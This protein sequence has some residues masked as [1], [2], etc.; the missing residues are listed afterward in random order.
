MLKVIT[1]C[2]LTS[3]TLASVARAED[4]NP[5]YAPSSLPLQ[6]PPFD[7]IE[8]QHFE[9]AILEG[10]R[11]QAQEVEAI[12]NS[13]EAPT[14]DNTIAAME[15]SGQLL[16]RVQHALGIIASAY[17]NPNLEK[18]QESVAPKL[19]AHQDAIT[20]N[21][22]LFKRIQKI[23][24]T[25]TQLKLTNEQTKLVEY[26][27]TT[28]VLAG[29][30]LTGIKKSKVK[31]LNEEEAKLSTQFVQRLMSATKSA[32]MLISDKEELDGLSQGDLDIAA[33]AAEAAGHK[34]QWLIS[35]QNTTQQ[36]VLASLKNRAVRERLF[37]LAWSRSE[38]E[39][40]D[41]ERALILR[42][43]SIRADKAKIM[44]FSNYATWKL[45]DQMAKTP[46]AVQKL[47]LDLG[48]PASAK[49]KA[50][51]ADIQ[52]LIDQQHGDFQLQ[53]WDW[54]F[55]AN[56]VR[57]AKYDVDESEVR[58]YFELNTVLNDGVF[59]AA[60]LLYG[61]TFK[62]RNDLPVFAPDVRVFDVMDKDGS[63][64]GLFYFDAFKRDN[65]NG[66]AWMENLV[67][68]TKLLGQKP[69]IFVATN[70]AK[71]TSGQAAL[72]NF[73]EVITLFHEFGHAL[74]GF[75][76]DQVYPTVSGTSTARDWV[77]FPSQF[78]EHWASDP[79]VF[80]NYAKH[81]STGAAMPQEMVEKIQKARF[82][83]QGYT[84]TE[85]LG[86]SHLD[87]QWHALNEKTVPKDVGAFEAKA[88]AS[89][90][91][92]LAQVPPRYRSTYFLHIWG[93]GYA[94][95]YYAYT[96]TRVLGDDAFSWFAENGGLTRENGQRFRDMILSRG[97]TIEY[98]KMFRDFRGR[99]VS[100]EAFLKYHGFA[101]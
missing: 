70:V 39:G 69:V 18:V 47:L 99:D 95:G 101:K 75:F 76:A 22:K 62:E 90:G 50:E 64:L 96:W 87:L 37:K 17:T 65:K 9:P 83:N 12:A 20:F 25:R 72:I 41:D 34:G 2:L 28:A 92:N 79:K 14:F 1:A 86:A 94:S 23:Y 15:R 27:Y 26:Y 74:H 48:A 51:S 38:Q 43:A 33:Q 52:A 98:A 71:P 66:G 54:E 49:V 84:L 30:K 8:D 80:A 61:L 4:K 67:T 58:P 29:A 40:K 42:L 32:A 53:A 68:Q 19:S 11:Q 97:N 63:Q 46:S 31:A 82:F 78:N 3:G 16:A 24:D 81:F 89:V 35:L 55:Y 59:Y 60:T 93:N 85:L 21:E 100:V 44:G 13:T 36:S 7:K 88:L 57:K 6:A 5:F 45:Q 10:I 73:D 56:Q 91:L 77:E